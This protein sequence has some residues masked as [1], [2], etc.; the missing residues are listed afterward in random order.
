MV[1]E[2]RRWSAG[3]RACAHAIPFPIQRLRRIRRV[4]GPTQP[5]APMMPPRS[6]VNRAVTSPYY[7]GDQSRP[8]GRLVTLYVVG[9]RSGPCHTVPVAPR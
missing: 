9:R 5:G 3:L 4:T 8:A 7:A 2:S 6:V 1:C